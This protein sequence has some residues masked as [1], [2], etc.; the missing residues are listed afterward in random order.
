[1]TESRGLPIFQIEKN[2]QNSM[3]RHEESPLATFTR[4]NSRGDIAKIEDLSGSLQTSTCQ[5]LDL[6]D[7]QAEISNPSVWQK[8]RECLLRKKSVTIHD[9]DDGSGGCEWN[10]PTIYIYTPSRDHDYSVPEGWIRGHTKIGPVRQVK[11]R[12]HSEQFGIEIQRKSMKSDGS[13]SWTVISGWMGRY[14]E[15]VFEERGESVHHEET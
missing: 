12:Y 14:V 2:L 1:M 10:I 9:L 13:L 7:K 8:K 15:E 6:P 11:V 5:G 4:E 3:T